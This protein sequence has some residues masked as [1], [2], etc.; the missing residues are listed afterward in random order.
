MGKRA[1]PPGSGK[2]HVT[3]EEKGIPSPGNKQ[4]GRGTIPFIIP[5]GDA[6]PGRN[7]HS[8]TAPP[9]SETTPPAKEGDR[10]PHLLLAEDDPSIRNL[11]ENILKLFNYTVDFAENGQRAV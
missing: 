3:S 8:A 1:T 9:S 7:V 5:L 10:I 6:G 11:L 4:A 2:R